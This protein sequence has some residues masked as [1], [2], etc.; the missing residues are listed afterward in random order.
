VPAGIV[1]VVSPA[2]RAGTSCW[3]SGSD[4]AVIPLSSVA[5]SATTLR[6]GFLAG[7][8]GQVLVTYGGRTQ[9]LTVEAGLHS[10]YLPVH[11]SS[12]AVLVQPVSGPLPCVGDVEAGAFLPASTGPAIPATP[13]VG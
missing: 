9:V 10:G 13:V 7:S 5:T 12:G 11:G 1:G 8:P 2:R 3:N 4:I 6:I